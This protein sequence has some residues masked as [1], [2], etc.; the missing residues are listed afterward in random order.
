MKISPRPISAS[1]RLYLEAGHAFPLAFPLA[2]W[3]TVVNLSKRS[4]QLMPDL[5]EQNQDVYDWEF[6]RDEQ[7]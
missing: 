4:F 3:Y 6:S 1:M 5:L 2:L 7:D